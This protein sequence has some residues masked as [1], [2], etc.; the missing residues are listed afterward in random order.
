[1]FVVAKSAWGARLLSINRP[2][3]EVFLI[4]RRLFS[5]ISHWIVF[6][7]EPPV[8]R[9]LLAGTARSGQGRASRRER[10]RTLAGEHR[11][12]RTA[13]DGRRS[14]NTIPS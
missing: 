14:G 6:P 10:E 2:K 5:R 4:W 9:W 1:L 8:A 7:P 12:G 13:I 3:A 11:S